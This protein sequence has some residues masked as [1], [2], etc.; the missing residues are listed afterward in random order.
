MATYGFDERKNKIEVS[1]KTETGT[2]S[3]LST[4]NK[5]SIVSAINDLKSEVDNV[6]TKS[7]VYNK[8]EIGKKINLFSTN[9]DGNGQVNISSD[10]FSLIAK[11]N[12]IGTLDSA[13]QYIIYNLDR[14]YPSSL[15]YNRVNF[16]DTAIGCSQIIVE[17][18]TISLVEY[19][20]L[21]ANNNIMRNRKSN[22]TFTLIGII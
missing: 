10:K 16:S 7:E 14:Q 9:T 4:T 3:N 20:Y 13:N 1:P 12:K 19:V 17:N 11:Y 6:Y 21:I 15:L 5:S 18:S 8:S 22:Y 2:L